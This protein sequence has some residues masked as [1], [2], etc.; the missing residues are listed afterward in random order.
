M[1]F[2]WALRR[3]GLRSICTS[4]AGRGLKGRGSCW[5]SVLIACFEAIRSCSVMN[6]RTFEVAKESIAGGG[7]LFL[8]PNKW[9]KAG[10]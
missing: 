4:V 8:A 5:I 10:A 1:E 6:V 3:S 9:E 7:S 2:G